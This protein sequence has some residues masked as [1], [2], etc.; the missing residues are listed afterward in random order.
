MIFS[1]TNYTLLVCVAPNSAFHT[2]HLCEVIVANWRNLYSRWMWFDL[3]QGA[4]HTSKPPTVIRRLRA[5]TKQIVPVPCQQLS[6]RNSQSDL[7]WQTAGLR[8]VCRSI[9]YG[10]FRDFLTDF[11]R[12]LPFFACC[13]TSKL[14]EVTT[15]SLLL[16]IMRTSKLIIKATALIVRFHFRRY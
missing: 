8:A 15:L 6:R 16:L 11:W 3:M 10:Q 2:Q 13:S 9:D 7:T 4:L 1:C 14:I 12:V 5:C